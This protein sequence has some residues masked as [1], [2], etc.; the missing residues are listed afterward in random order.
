MSRDV[1]AIFADID[2]FDPD[3]FVA[4]LADDVVFRFASA[5]PVIG[6]AGVKEAVTAFFAT[7]GGLTHHILNVWEVG[8]TTITQID[9]E[10][11]R[12]D[13]AH[14]TVPNADIITFRGD[15]VSHWLIYIDLAPVFADPPTAT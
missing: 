11:T 12:L 4:H 10:Y 15:L 9:V 7:I 6:R 8:D 3:R 13:G 14:V 1:R 5:E 2:S